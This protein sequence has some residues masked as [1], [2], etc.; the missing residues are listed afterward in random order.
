[1]VFTAC[2]S[3]YQVL[4]PKKVH[5]L[6]EQVSCK[7]KVVITVVLGFVLGFIVGLTS[8]GSGSLFAIVMLFIYRLL[9]AELVGTDI[10]ML[11]FL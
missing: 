10:V 11:F 1:M 7:T 2:V 3:L 4:F 6:D 8:V 9:P 5:V